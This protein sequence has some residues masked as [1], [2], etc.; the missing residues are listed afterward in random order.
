MKNRKGQ[1]T[2][3]FLL[4][5]AASL[6]VISLLA[7]LLI[8]QGREIAG[9][10]E[11]TVKISRAESAA[12]AAE[13]AYRSGGELSVDFRDEDVSHSVENGRFHVEHDGRLIEIGGVFYDDAA[14]PV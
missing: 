8:L 2:I 6:A 3:E 13:V 4:V 11:E 10:A 5:F 1:V 7:G 14:E 12:R 9:K